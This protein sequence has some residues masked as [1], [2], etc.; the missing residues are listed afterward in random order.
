[1]LLIQHCSYKR[2]VKQN[3]KHWHT[4][5][6]KLTTERDKYGAEIAQIRVIQG[7]RNA[8]IKDLQHSNDSLNIQ[9]SEAMKE[10]GRGSNT[11]TVINTETIIHDTLTTIITAFDT[12]V[13]D[14]TVTVWP[15]YFST[16]R[17]GHI[18]DTIIASRDSTT[19]NLHIYN[20]QTLDVKKKRNK[21]VITVKNSNPH[22]TTSGLKSWQMDRL[23][24][25]QI[26]Y[27]VYGSYSNRPDFTYQGGGY[28]EL[29]H[30]I[31]T[32][33]FVG[34]VEMGIGGLRPLVEVKAKFAIQRFPY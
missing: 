24:N 14:D 13:I 34:G 25:G 22:I 6:D 16:F 19:R 17:D 5:T 33:E 11:V 15:V 31:I 7:K 10:S 21:Y 27:G 20:T 28:F 1:M 23:L 30:K 18:A 12:V 8:V 9:L 3:D 29:K 4:I 2:A 32:A 26:D